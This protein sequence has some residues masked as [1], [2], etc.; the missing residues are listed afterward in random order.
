MIMVLEIAS[1]APMKALCRK[2]QPRARP[3]MKP[4]QVAQPSWTVPSTMAEGPFSSSLRKS[5]SRPTENISRTTPSSARVMDVV[6]VGHQGD[7]DMRPDDQAS[8]HVAQHRR[9]FQPP[10]QQGYDRGHP[11]DGGQIKDESRNMGFHDCNIRLI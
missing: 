8:Q 6:Q 4:S 2:L 7:R 10:E 11:Q 1:A 5:N 9:L 3:A